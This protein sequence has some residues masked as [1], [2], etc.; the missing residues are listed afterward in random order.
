M[1]LGVS[2]RRRTRLSGVYHDTSAV[3]EEAHAF[4]TYNDGTF[5]SHPCRI[6]S[7]SLQ[8]NISDIYTSIDSTTMSCGFDVLGRDISF[9]RFDALRYS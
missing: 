5:E 1:K 2:W 6:L 3:R 8:Q 9:T 7:E 4:Y